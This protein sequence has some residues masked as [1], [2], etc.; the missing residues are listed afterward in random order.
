MTTLH[1]ASESLDS[2]MAKH[3]ASPDLCF[4]LFTPVGCDAVHIGLL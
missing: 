3:I 4:A 1:A 2:Q